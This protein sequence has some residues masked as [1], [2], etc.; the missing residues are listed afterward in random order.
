[1]VAMRGSAMASDSE[2]GPVAVPPPVVYIA[3]LIAGA[4]LD[5]FFPTWLL[6]RNWASAVGT[7]LIVASILIVLPAILRFRRAGTPFNVR[8][9]ASALVTDGPYRFSRNPGYVALT[10]LY[11]GLSVLLNN[12]WALFLAVPAVLVMDLWV[13]RKEERHL[14]QKF[15]EEYRSY[16]ARVRR[17]L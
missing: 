7:V 11:A 5:Y 10:V 3:A 13:V 12:A 8:K 15:G 4:G 6:P 9:P 1:M 14:E 17:W 2:R 16:R